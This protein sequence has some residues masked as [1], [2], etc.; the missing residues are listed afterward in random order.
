LYQNC[1]LILKFHFLIPRPTNKISTKNRQSKSV[2]CVLDAS[3]VALQHTATHCNTDWSEL[4]T[5]FVYTT[6]VLSHCNILQNTATHNTLIYQGSGLALCTRR[7]FCRTATHCNTLQH[8]A[9]HCTIRYLGWWFTSCTMQRPLTHCN[10][11]QHTTVHCNLPQHAATCFNK[12]QHTPTCCSI[13]QLTAN[14]ATHSNTPQHN[15]TH[16]NTQQR[17]AKHTLQHL[18]QGG[19]ASYTTYTTQTLDVLQYTATHCNTLQHT[20]THRN[21]HIPQDTAT[22]LPGLTGVIHRTH[23]AEPW[24]A[25]THCNTLQRTATHRNTHTH[26]PKT[27]QHLYPGWLA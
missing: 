4:R 24:R 3:F 9:T 15:E 21:T 17:T 18:Y 8:T 23:H 11:L 26:K 25:A 22:S 14:A 10:T 27:L 5:R 13:L 20:A 19:L 2:Y 6:R 12:L 1:S 16:R 7:E